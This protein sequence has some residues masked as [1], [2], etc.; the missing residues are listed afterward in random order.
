MEFTYLDWAATAPPDPE[1]LE[2]ARR[3]A[4]ENF[5]NPSS[6]HSSGKAA[7][8]VLE[9]SRR[10]IAKNL[11]C[12]PEQ[13]YFT[14]GGTESNNIVFSNLLMRPKKG[15]TLTS[16]IEHSCVWEA[17]ETMNS[18]GFPHTGINPGS[19]G[20][21]TPQKAVE[22]LS[23]KTELVSIMLVNN[24]TGSI[25]DI[26][27]LHRA[28]NDSFPGGRKPHFHSDAVQ[29]LGKIPVNLTELGIDSASFSG[30]KIGA[31]RGIGLVYLKKPLTALFR[32]GGQENGIR[33]GTENLPAIAALATVLAKRTEE[34]DSSMHRAAEIRGRVVEGLKAVPE[35]I[36]LPRGINPL[37]ER[38]VPNILK[39]SFPPV[40]GEVLQRVLSDKGIMVSTGS[41]CSSNQKHKANR[42]LKA[43]GTPPGIAE[44]SIR[45]SWG[46][47]T[48]DDEI[49]M[50]I[51]T[52]VKEIR[53]LQEQLR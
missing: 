21:I 3:V 6:L 38:L 26:P 32:G 8:A 34:L 53:L 37:D 33:P 43:M 1:A 25:Q 48:G 44:S 16:T 27:A 42:V 52:A 5:G 4:L 2:T 41:A 9:E 39:C 19:D 22:K 7:A 30:H 13:L 35:V 46:P 11:G 45:F 17:A 36:F 51:R 12:R 14:S 18:L 24:E 47:E 15:A 49:E 23:P 29:A 31:P 50:F 20:L 40:P 28:I 10:S